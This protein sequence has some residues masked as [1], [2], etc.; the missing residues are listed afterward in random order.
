MGV[1]ANAFIS[2]IQDTEAGSET[3]KKK[4]KVF[5]RYLS[6]IFHYYILKH[7]L[8]KIKLY[9]KGTVKSNIVPISLQSFVTLCIFK[10]NL[11]NAIY[12]LLKKVHT[13]T[14][15]KFC[16]TFIEGFPEV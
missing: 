15:Y 13:Y 5:P 2:S 11:I 16:V 10:Q 4:K 3:L 7:S 1:V 8:P 6:V 14:T 12:F 9:K